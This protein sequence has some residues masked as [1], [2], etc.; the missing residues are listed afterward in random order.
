MLN[1][2]RIDKVYLALGTT[3]LRKSIDG[4]SIYQKDAH[5]IIKERIII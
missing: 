4:L 2:K 1:Q 3:D 5:P